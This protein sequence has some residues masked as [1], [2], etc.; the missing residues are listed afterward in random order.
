MSFTSSSFLR[1]ASSRTLSPD[2]PFTSISHPHA[3]EH[4]QSSARRSA[5]WGITV[6]RQRCASFLSSSSRSGS[7]PKL[8]LKREPR[9]APDERTPHPHH[10]SDDALATHLYH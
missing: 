8:P 10:S 1:C 2:R 9:K 3:K 4:T 5:A 6:C 7:Q